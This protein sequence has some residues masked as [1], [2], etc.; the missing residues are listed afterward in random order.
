MNKKDR[1]L[2]IIWI[3]V[4]VLMGIPDWIEFLSR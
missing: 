2:I 3:V 1:V 4:L